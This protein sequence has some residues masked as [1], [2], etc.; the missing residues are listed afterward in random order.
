MNPVPATPGHQDHD[1]RGKAGFSFAMM[2]S[3]GRAREGLTE[4]PA[5]SPGV[6][7]EARHSEAMKVGCRCCA[8]SR[9]LAD[10]ARLELGR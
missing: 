7:R 10:R 3:E 6:L 1:S 5:H 4:R 8:A 2:L 9:G